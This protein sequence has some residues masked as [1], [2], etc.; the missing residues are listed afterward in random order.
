MP[1]EKR[2]NKNCGK[3]VYFYFL[4]FITPRLPMSVQKKFQPIRSSRFAGYREH[5]HECLVLVSRKQLRCQHLLSLKV[6]MQN[7]CRI[8]SG[9]GPQPL[10]NLF[11]VN[12]NRFTPFVDGR[13][14]SL[15][16]STRMGS[17]PL[18]MVD[19]KVC[20]SQRVWVHTLC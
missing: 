9:L 13:C 17:H 19:V 14:Q 8:Y 4:A 12:E 20:Y 1:V 2:K 15:L 10:Y 18:L 7:A 5:I 11:T 6:S 16:Q 3:K